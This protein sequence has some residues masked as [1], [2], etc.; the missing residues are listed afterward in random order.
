MTTQRQPVDVVTG[1]DRTRRSMGDGTLRGRSRIA[2][3]HDPRR[4][5]RP[6]A[7]VTPRMS[8]QSRPATILL[9]AD[10]VAIPSGEPTVVTFG[11]QA[12][13]QNLVAWNG[14][15]DVLT[16]PWT[17]TI[18]LYVEGAWDDHDPGDAIVEIM[19]GETIVWNVRAASL[20]DGVLLV[21]QVDDVSV[22]H[23]TDVV[24]EFTVAEVQNRI[25][26]SGPSDEIVWPM[27][28]TVKLDVA[29]RWTDTTVVEKVEV[30]I[31]DAAVWPPDWLP[32]PGLEVD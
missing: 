16:W 1:L 10:D 17:G 31:D 29:G 24:V 25:N 30:L 13:V 4:L 22:P 19:I 11:E 8:G 23:A 32:L 28:G 27:P 12:V 3:P 7:V 15:S 6:G 2:T 26:W 14:P 9:T 21:L 5:K 20:A 18:M